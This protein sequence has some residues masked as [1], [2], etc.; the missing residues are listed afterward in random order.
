M[1]KFKTYLLIKLDEQLDIIENSSQGNLTEYQCGYIAG[2][3][4][5]LDL[6]INY[7]ESSE[8]QKTSNESKP[9]IK[10]GFRLFSK[11]K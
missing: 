9:H 11:R 5:L 1:Q 2:I 10:P 6:I 8:K 7:K 4:Y 3:N